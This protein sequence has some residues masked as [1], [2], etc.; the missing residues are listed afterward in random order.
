MSLKYSLDAAVKE[1]K[2]HGL[3]TIEVNRLPVTVAAAG[4]GVGFGTAVLGALPTGFLCITQTKASLAFSTSDTDLAATFNGDFS[5][6]S[7]PDADGALAGA[8]IDVVPSTSMGP[9]VARVTP[10]ATGRRAVGS[11]ALFLDNT[12]GS[13][14]LNLNV[15]VDAA[16]ITDA[17]NGIVLVT[18]LVQLM[19]G[20][21][22]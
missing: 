18:G 16:D 4:A 8:E 14:E 5:V 3:L 6:G 20:V 19:I 22:P 2:V 15:L 21:L 9:A 1:G 10:A 11:G 7:A 12:A 17:T 13:L